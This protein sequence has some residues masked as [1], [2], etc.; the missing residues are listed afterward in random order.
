M[1]P[2]DCCV[3]TTNIQVLPEFSL[4]LGVFYKRDLCVQSKKKELLKIKSVVASFEHTP[5]QYA[6]E[7]RPWL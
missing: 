7:E 1:F 2:P 6:K 5:E 3:G 4:V